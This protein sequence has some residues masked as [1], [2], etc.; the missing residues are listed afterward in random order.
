MYLRLTA[1]HRVFAVDVCR[2]S[3]IDQP[4]PPIERR[5]SHSTKI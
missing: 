1:M 3:W 5:V 2:M 4:A